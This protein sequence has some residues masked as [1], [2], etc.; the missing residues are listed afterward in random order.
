MP[1]FFKL[2]RRWQELAVLVTLMLLTTPVFWLTAWDE[3]AAAWFF[4]PNST[5]GNWP[6]QHWWLWQLLYQY[7]F[8]FIILA[9]AVALVVTGL[10]VKVE[11]LKAYRRPALY[12]VWVLVLGPGLVIN[13]VFKDH[14]GRPRPVHMQ[15]F[16]GQHS[17]VP[18]LK[19]GGTG[20][21]SF[22]CGHCSVGYAFFVFYF[23]SSRRKF[24]LLC[25][26]LAVA[27]TLAAAR[28]SAGGHFVSDVL[29]SGYLV[30]FTAW[31]VYYGWYERD[32]KH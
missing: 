10:S 26:T 19:L 22:P 23:L 4:E 9:G 8:S 17:Y 20:E 2:D 16:G 6:H 12:I 29:W 1:W 7:A 15:T 25:L 14:W 30:F 27:F 18:P 31:L 32:I 5:A 28:M 11:F 13:L 24:W 3:K 21:K